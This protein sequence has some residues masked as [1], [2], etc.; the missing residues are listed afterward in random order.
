MEK[1]HT[2]GSR[3]HVRSM[4]LNSQIGSPRQTLSEALRYSFIVQRFCG[5]AI[6]IFYL[7][8]ISRE[9][10]ILHYFTW[11]GKEFITIQL[12]IHCRDLPRFNFNR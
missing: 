3:D 6:P 10:N 2:D 1:I 11:L 12:F 8:D 7:R 9:E 4:H 5:W